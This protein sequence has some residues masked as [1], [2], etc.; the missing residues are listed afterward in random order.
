M[1]AALLQLNSIGQEDI[2]LTS[3]PEITFFK[4]TYKKYTNFCIETLEHTVSGDIDFGSTMV[5]SISKNSDLL[6]KIFLKIDISAQTSGTNSKVGK[7]AWINNIGHNIIDKIIFEIGNHEIDRQYGSWLNIWYELNRNENHED[8]Y[9]KLIGNTSF[10]T[11]LTKGTGLEDDKKITLFIPLQ[12]Y[13][14]RN[15][16]VSLPLIA[17]DHHDVSIKLNLK[18]SK[19]LINKT[20]HKNFTI[21]PKVSN[22]T[23]LI[24]H[25]FLDT[26]ERR[27]FS[28]SSHEYLIEQTQYNTYKVNTINNNFKLTFNSSV[29]ALYWNIISGKYI[30]QQVYLSNNLETATKKFILAFFY[31]DTFDLGTTFQKLNIDSTYPTFEITHLNAIYQISLNK[32]NKN[33]KEIVNTAY[34]NRSNVS[35]SN[36]TL[37]DITV[38]ELLPIDIASI[39]S[40]KLVD[41]SDTALFKEN[42]TPTRITYTNAEIS[43]EDDIVLNDFNNYGIYIDNSVSPIDDAILKLNGQDR[44]TKQSGGYFNFVQPYQHFISTPKIGINCY[45]FALNPSEYQPSGTCNFSRFQH[46]N[47]DLTLKS[48]LDITTNNSFIYIYSTNYNMLKIENGMANLVYLI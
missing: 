47:L 20:N 14:C 42:Y 40:S 24:D 31:I 41:C 9:N 35:A 36:I 33:L 48:E 39:I 7:W 11:T 2:Y 3:N 17:L 43:S 5:C 22:I 4:T 28:Q 32:N 18:D 19:Y 45:S 25:I 44:F 27:F 10:A 6:S 37:A 46:I 38:P 34:I 26:T 15:Y 8:G 21:K 13:F 12:F 16:S 23:L 1:S 29:K 30:N